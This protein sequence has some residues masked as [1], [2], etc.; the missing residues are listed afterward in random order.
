MQKITHEALVI[1]SKLWT[2]VLVVVLAIAGKVGWDIVNKRKVSFLYVLGFSAMA[3]FVST[4]VYLLCEYKKVNPTLSAVLVG[5]SAI[6]SRDILVSVSLM[7][8]KEIIRVML[9][10]K[11]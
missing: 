8:W 11:P 3:M 7:N 2:Y 1:F 9:E 5:G 6:F 10:K 4:M